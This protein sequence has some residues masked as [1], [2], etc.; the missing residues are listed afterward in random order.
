MLTVIMMTAS[1]LS[2]EV[3]YLLLGNCD[4]RSG[5]NY[6]VYFKLNQYE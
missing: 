1:M 5:M 4:I 3:H 6:L 2:V